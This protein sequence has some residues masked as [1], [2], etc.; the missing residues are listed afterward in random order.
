MPQHRRPRPLCWAL[1][2][3]W[4]CSDP[5]ANV[6]AA[7]L[8]EPTAQAANPAPSSRKDRLERLAITPDNARI[9]WAAAKLH[10]KEEGAFA[11]FDGEVRLDPT[12]LEG[13]E[14]EVRIQTASL[15]AEPDRLAD[16]LRD[17]DFLDAKRFPEA[18]FRSLSIRP[19][20][21]VKDATHRIGGELTLHGQTHRIAFPAH[22][23]LDSE[24]R[25]RAEF[26]INRIDFEI[27]P[28]RPDHLIRHRVAIRLTLDLPRPER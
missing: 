22:I 10:V 8:G 1:L 19:S 2:T 25:V 28:K 27:A 17:V 20:T 26:S 14:V 4:A 21:D 5:G 7:A 24:L 16:H 9:E 13:S 11:R 23:A 15:Q 3:L 18:R 12:Q 6:P